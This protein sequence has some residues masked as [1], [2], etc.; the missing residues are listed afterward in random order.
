MVSFSDNLMDKLY[1]DENVCQN[2]DDGKVSVSGSLWSFYLIS[3]RTIIMPEITW[4]LVCTWTWC[5]FI[6]SQAELSLLS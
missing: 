4:F 3:G 6:S 1:F 2:D 5:I